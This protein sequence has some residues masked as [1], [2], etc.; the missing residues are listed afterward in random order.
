MDLIHVKQWKEREINGFTLL[1][2]KAYWKKF[3]LRIVVTT[4]KHLLMETGG[5]KS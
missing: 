1:K 4:L 5:K 3:Y 2:K